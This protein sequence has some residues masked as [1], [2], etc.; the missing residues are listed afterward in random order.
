MVAFFVLESLII[1]VIS[2]CLVDGLPMSLVIMVV[3]LHIFGLHIWS[4][5]S[6]IKLSTGRLFRFQLS[7]LNKYLLMF[8]LSSFGFVEKKLFSELSIW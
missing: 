2:L 4:S 6:K 7:H 5:V 1:I 3:V 8:V